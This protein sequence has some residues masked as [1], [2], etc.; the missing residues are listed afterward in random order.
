MIEELEHL[1][2]IENV[3]NI[4]LVK[5]SLELFTTLTRLNTS[6]DLVQDNSEL[7]HFINWESK[8]FTQKFIEAVEEIAKPV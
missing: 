4:F 3:N 1:K 6:G 2:G 5:N 7:N 8:S